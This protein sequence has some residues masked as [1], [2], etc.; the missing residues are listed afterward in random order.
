MVKGK[1]EFG[2]F[3][4]SVNTS[5]IKLQK[6][7]TDSLKFLISL[8]KNI[9]ED[10]QIVYLQNLQHYDIVTDF[11]K[12][13]NIKDFYKLWF[14]H[15]DTIARIS[16][17]FTV[18]TNPDLIKQTVAYIEFKIKL[19]EPYEALSEDEM[20][21]LNY[22]RNVLAIAMLTKNEA[23]VS[24][25]LIDKLLT[26][27]SEL[28]YNGI[29]CDVIEVK[30]SKIHG[31]GVFAKQDI[32]TGSV[33]TLY[34]VDG[35]SDDNKTYHITDKLTDKT[36]TFDD[37][38]YVVNDDLKI[39]ADASKF[40]NPVQLG[41]MINDSVGNTFVG[42]TVHNIKDGVYEYVMKSNNNCSIKVNQKYGLIYVVVT[43]NIDAGEE[44]LTSY[45]PAFWFSRVSDDLKLFYEV[46][47]EGKM[48]EFLQTNVFG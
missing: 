40:D 23:Y 30:D 6:N 22:Y 38:S 18:P 33:V 4:V 5:N 17:L 8:W 43:R 1:K 3:V 14:V 12:K 7:V 9:E 11:V 32:K 27:S 13:S 16:N 48:A 10:N 44:L 39:V 29:N 2:E 20:R 24:K 47:S 28:S 34:P 19:S 26:N 15:V 31:K 46:C 36:N 41:H 45:S 42:T 25:P 37:H 35:Y 21:L